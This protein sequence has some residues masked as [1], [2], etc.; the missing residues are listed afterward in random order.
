M[1]NEKERPKCPLIGA[2]S[3]IFYLIG[4]ASRSLK[5]A[6]M[7]KEAWEM[8]FRIHTE[9]EDYSQAFVIIGEYVG[10]SSREDEHE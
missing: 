2:D 5:R 3:N 1:M 6:G 9:A 10:L 7:P 8:A 4:L